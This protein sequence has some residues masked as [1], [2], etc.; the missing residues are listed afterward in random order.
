MTK[1]RTT[2]QHVLATLLAAH[3]TPLTV[4]DLR[5]RLGPTPPADSTVRTVL[6]MGRALGWIERVQIDPDPRRVAF[7]LTEQ[8]GVL[9]ARARRSEG[10]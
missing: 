5:G 2:E 9:I 1:P 10:Q 7:R 8:E 3:P 6:R 4:A